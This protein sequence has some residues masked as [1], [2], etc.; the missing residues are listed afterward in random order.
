MRFA[1]FRARWYPGYWGGS[2]LQMAGDNAEHA[3]TYWVMWQYFHSPLLAGFAVVSHWVPHLLFSIPFGA[4]ADRYDARRIVQV[5]AGLFM[6]ASVCWGVLILT[7][8]LQAW[9][10]VVLLL[11]HGFASALWHPADK[12]LLYDMVGRDLLPSGIRLVATAISLG[13]VVGPAFGALLLFTVGPGLGMLLNVLVY[14]PFFVYL[15]ALPYT[16]H[17]RGGQAVTRMRLR[18]VFSVLRDLPRYPA[19]L[20]VMTLQAA[21]G[22]LIGVALMP[23]LPEFSELLGIDD[24]GVAYALLLIAMASGAVL[25]GVALEA[26]GRLR[27]DPRLA[28]IGGALFAA[29][30]LTFALSREVAVSL[31]ALFVA[32]IATIVADSASQTVVQLEAPDDRRGRFVG[33]AQVTSM[34]SRAGSGALIGILAT[35]VGVSAAVAIDAALLLLIAL[36]LLAVLLT[37]A[38]RGRAGSAEET[39]TATASRSARS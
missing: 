22:L 18:D 34:G 33:A 23:L 19:V 38:A 13:Q 7:G 28:V 35:G 25:G 24:S 31:A 14:I 32:G 12:V 20:V 8:T 9:H 26:I 37:R 4:L 15:F 1:V 5:A 3:I 11:V 2:A 27:P 30:V 21:I 39:V 17:R 36:A 10:A 6:V 16:G 29:A